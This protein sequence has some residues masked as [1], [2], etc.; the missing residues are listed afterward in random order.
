MGSSRYR[1]LSGPIG[2]PRK[3]AYLRRGWGQ[4]NQDLARPFAAG[5]PERARWAR[6]WRRRWIEMLLGDGRPYPLDDSFGAI[7]LL[8]L[9]RLRMQLDVDLFGFGEHHKV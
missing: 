2:T 4:S 3:R 6:H 1:Y 7:E 9:D 5:F 8:R